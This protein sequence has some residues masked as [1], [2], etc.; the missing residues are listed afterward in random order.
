MT[1][2]RSSDFAVGCLAAS[3]LVFALAGCH[4]VDN[5][6]L[7]GGTGDVPAVQDVAAD[8]QDLQYVDGS[9]DTMDA[10]DVQYADVVDAMDAAVVDAVDVPVVVDAV[11][12]LVPVDVRADTPSPTDASDT[13]VPGPCDAGYMLV[14]AGDYLI[15]ADP[16]DTD[17]QLNEVPQFTA[18]L[19]AFCMK[20]TEVTV[21]EFGACVTGGACAVLPGVTL[22]CN[23]GVVGRENHP[24][25]CVDWNQATAYCSYSGGRLPTEAEWEGAARGAAWHPYP[26]GT[27]AP[28]NSLANFD[29]VNGGTQEGTLLDRCN[30]PFSLCDMAG[31]VLEWVHDCEGSYAAGRFTNPTGPSGAACTVTTNR[32]RRGGGWNS[33]ALSVR[34]SFREG[35][36][37][38]YTSNS[39]GIRCVQPAR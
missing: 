23:W 37:P 25:N 16:A 10:G 32:I 36:G 27:T 7:E 8:A 38:A 18:A 39:L 30:N 12:L 35:R 4:A 20:R 2:N 15:G 11:D 21:T 14:P 34:S 22:G 31:N 6:L 33:L 17:R 5:R 3:A 1:S 26:W 24:V 13:G 28:N 29:S 19:S 9:Q